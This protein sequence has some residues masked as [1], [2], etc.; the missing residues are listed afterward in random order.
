MYWIFILV[1]QQLPAGHVRKGAH[2]VGR[3][4]R[5]DLA[6][7]RRAELIETGDAEECHGGGDFAFEQFEDSH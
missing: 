4:Q 6:Q 2:L 7:M 5:L 3:R 1:S